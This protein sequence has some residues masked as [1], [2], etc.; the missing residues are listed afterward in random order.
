MKVR[1]PF[2]LLLAFSI[3]VLLGIVSCSKAPSTEPTPTPVPTKPTPTTTPTPT[4]TPTPSPMS[5]SELF[6]RLSPSLAYIKTPVGAGTGLLLED[7]YILTAAHIVLPYEKVR[8]AF[9]DR[10]EF[11]DVPVYNL[12]LI[13]D[14]AVLGP[15]TTTLPGQSLTPKED[16]EIGSEV[17]LLGYPGEVEE[18]P[19]PTISKGLI[20]RYRQWDTLDITFFQTDAAV[21]GGQSGGI[22]ITPQGQIIGITVL[23]LA[24]K[25]YALAISAE[26]ALPRI[27][28]MLAGED[29][30]GIDWVYTSKLKGYKK[31]TV[32]LKGRWDLRTFI[33][34]EPKDMKVDLEIKGPFSLF[35]PP[36]E[37]EV[38]APS[39]LSVL[40]GDLSFGGAKE[41]FKVYTEGPHYL[42][43]LPG[44]YQ[45]PGKNVTISSNVMLY[46]HPEGDVSPLVKAG[47][48][49]SA[50]LDY[51][52][53]VD[54]F[55]IVL[56]PGQKV[57]IHVSSIMIDPAI[58]VDA[59]DNP[60]PIESIPVDSDSGGGL[61]GTDA[62]LTFEAPKLATYAILV[63]G[64]EFDVGGY[65]LEVREVY[66]GAPTPVA[67]SPTPVPLRAE[68]G[69]MYLYKSDSPPYFKI[70]YPADWVST[71][72]LGMLK[73]L[74]EFANECFVDPSG[75][76]ALVIV[77][78]D[79]RS[80]GMENASIEDY[81]DLIANLI[82]KGVVTVRSRKTR[83]NANG[84]EIVELS[85]ESME[86]IEGKRWIS[87]YGN[88]AF[89]ATFMAFS[90]KGEKAIPE[91]F[92]KRAAEEVERL[93]EYMFNT[94]AVEE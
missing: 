41:S 14:L 35:A 71:R 49:V 22:L 50:A 76:L 78:E 25:Q 39:K 89:N 57:N 70:Q 75:A 80:L 26:D 91:Y 40:S 20:S 33:I 67:P 13:A 32:N 87:I 64:G 54:L 79:L 83:E 16:L 62:E 1:K 51:P 52:G 12:D 59:I 19:K 7:G 3:V 72:S 24:Q 11:S 6:D 10:T 90:F 65:V 63:L 27:K 82:G 38:I 66:E 8:V 55:R 68:L 92:R 21:A 2:S 29:V 15:I 23:A 31:Q 47:Q 85:W 44:V 9:P 46:K 28:R 43:L 36:V 74:C 94:I 69:D 84:L 86:Q 4:G 53:D 61:L 48:I 18:F 81:A 73:N 42:S 60:L 88:K 17:Y 5:P 37:Y 56:H 45:L 77:E 93:A 34:D 58:A 30:D